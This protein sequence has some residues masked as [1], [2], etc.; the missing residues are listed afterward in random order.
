MRK[1]I[2][3]TIMIAALFVFT[4]L[5]KAQEF[6][7][8]AGIGLGAY[9]AD[10]GIAGIGKQTAFG[11]FGQFGVDIGKY[12]GG[13][14]RLGTSSNTTFVNSGVSEEAKLDYVFS[15]LAKIQ[16]PVSKNLRVY[17]LVGGTSGQVTAKITTPGFVFAATGTTSISTTKTSLSVGGGI[18]FRIQDKISFG[19]EY[20]RYYSDVSGFSANFKYLF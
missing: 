20:M 11:G 17:A 7:P 18:D 13:E 6:K 8:Y 1:M 12:Y 14:L 2:S 3:S 4:P 19:V 5:S 15:Y 9:T 10:T 16:A